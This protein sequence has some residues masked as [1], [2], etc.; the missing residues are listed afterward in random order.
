M[1]TDVHGYI[2][3]A[4]HDRCV[5]V[6]IF[7][8]IV[9][10]FQLT[11]SW[12]F[13]AALR[14]CVICLR[15]SLKWNF[16]IALAVFLG[17]AA[18][19]AAQSGF[20]FFEPVTPPRAVQIMAHRGLAAVA[21]ENSGEAVL[22]CAADFIEWA[23]VDVRLTKDR[24]HVIFHDDRLERTTDGKGRVTDITAD[25]FVKLD[26]GA[27]NAPRF[28]GARPLT[29]AQMLETARGKINLYLDCKQVDPE[30]LATE[31]L[32]SRMESQVVIYDAP[33]RLSRLRAKSGK[34]IATMAK[35]RPKT[36]EFEA[37][38][39]EVDPDA[40]EIDADDVTADWCRRFHARG[41]KVQAKVLGPDWDN[42]ATW[43]KVIEAGVDWLQTDDPAG[44]RFT[45]V[46]RRLKTF[47]VKIAHHRGTNRY[48]PENTL[49]AIH[50]AVALSADYIEI[51][52]RTTADGQFV[53]MHDRTLNRTTD[54]RGDV[55][56]SAAEDILRLDAGSW[57]G[58]QFAGTRV[59]A[60]EEAL[61]ARASCGMYLD[62][63]DISPESLLGAMRKHQ[64]L[65]N[66]VVYQSPVYLAKLRTL[67]PGVRTLPPLGSAA[68]FEAVARER[69][70]GVDV[71][72]SALS[73][74]LIERCREAGI[75]VFSDALGPNERIEEYARALEWKI[76]VIQ[77]DYPL[78]VLRAVELHSFH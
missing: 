6:S 13:F 10:P 27:W 56:Q 66:S 22:A 70:F 45:D 11:L 17:S 60:L 50:R 5:S 28:K 73:R 71:K 58:R 54:G 37:F 72:W 62:A 48:A 74:E 38:V 68:E 49:P 16:P 32:D 29:L 12:I 65:G 33:A 34:R 41:I 42:P 35:F 18:P 46:R 52:I 36:M 9:M 3:P 55:S 4:A 67:E 19:L 24:R 64:L 8:Q 2:T 43:T 14:L 39:R 20:A 69:P 21:P 31:I 47:P 61:A 30:L 57:F 63:K 76:D 44:V 78:R 25:E 53:L 7:G 15:R 40:V 77:T 23:E 51:D 26:T 59:P 1:H 75:Q